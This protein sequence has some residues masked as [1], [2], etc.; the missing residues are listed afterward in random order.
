MSYGISRA[1]VLGAG[2][3]GSGIAAHLANAGIPVRLLDIAS[4][5]DGPRDARA[6]DAITRLLAASPSPFLTREAAAL[7]SP[8]T[9]EDDLAQLADCDWI[10][11]AVLEDLP[12]KQ[13]LY[14]RLEAVRHD[15]AI[16]TSNTSTIPLAQLVAGRSPAFAAHFAVTHFFNPP[17]WMSLL[18]LVGGP[19]TRPAVLDALQAFGDL[20]LGKRVVRCHDT[21]G[22]IAN[23]IGTFTLQIALQDAIAL[24]LR[25][26]DADAICGKP[27][28]LPKT[29]VFGLLDLVGLD[30]MPRVTASLLANLPPHDRYRRL[31]H[32]TPIVATLVAAGFTGRKGGG[33]FYRITKRADGSKQ[34][35]VVDLA[36]GALRDAGPPTLAS[37]RARHLRDL[38]AATDV[39]GE[40]A[41]RVL[42]QLWAYAFEVGPEIADD[43]A[44][45]DRA[46]R[47][48]FGWTA[49]PFEMADA[50]GLRAVVTLLEQR[51]EA[52]PPR[53]AAAVAAG[54]CYRVAGG[55]LEQ[56]DAT[57]GWHAVRRPEGVETLA[58]VTRRAR[59][60][61]KNGSA[62]LWDLGDRVLG[63]EFK[64]KMNA[65]DGDVMQLLH[66]AIARAGQG[67][68]A[69]G[70]IVLHNDGAHFSVGA[71]LGVLLYAINLAAWR[72]AEKLIIAGQEAYAALRAAPVPV[73]GVH[74][75]MALGGGCEA[76]LHCDAVVAHVEAT[77]GLVETGVGLIP[78]WGGCTRMLL[79]A[80]AAGDANDPMAAIV[81]T[82]ELIGKAK[83]SKNAV[84]AKRLGL[85]MPHDVIV[86]HPDRLLDEAKR[87]AREMAPTY[88]PPTP[89]RVRLPGTALVPVIEAGVQ[90][91]VAAGEA[92]AY[93]AVVAGA[94]ARV[95]TGGEATLER[96][97]R[98]RDLLALEREAF[99]RLMREPK[100]RE[101]VEHMLATGT[102]LRN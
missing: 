6:R 24:G 57:G 12:T 18:E 72:D 15:Q 22:F 89:A 76:L 98:E 49:G 38:L 25:V 102:P 88:V 37:A 97:V 43:F 44:S 54:G 2:V 100:T 16:I 26:E 94:L 46:M 53:L 17:R 77:M 101:R 48:G 1:A 60:L 21:P 66:R 31:V 50:L 42:T 47:D 14:E 61:E 51:G 7:V 23:R 67:D 86:M 73:I 80:I 5:G 41:R 70:A 84:D 10:I 93:D 82:M 79:R 55:A 9:L 8:G 63:V 13:A 59:P 62:A 74:H 58:D 19:A 87:V 95:L 92:T 28:G 33:G 34:T 99:L 96:T 52:I 71:N 36:S 85:L 11:E 78:G 68:G 64:A 83:T 3:M 56:S 39:G 40:L 75:G 45:V 4:S 65:L 69:F 32:E 91:L 29:G 90:G 35:Q 27:M 20:R 81:R 30:L